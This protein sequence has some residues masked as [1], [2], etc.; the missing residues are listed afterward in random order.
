MTIDLD[1]DRKI[2][3]SWFKNAAPWIVAVEEQQIESRKLITD[4]FSKER[5]RQRLSMRWLVVAVKQCW[6]W[7]AAKAG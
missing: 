5:L 1:N 3:D 4:R 7:V 6:I 2:I